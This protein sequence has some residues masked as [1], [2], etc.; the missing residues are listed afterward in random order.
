MD[1][2]KSLESQRRVMRTPGSVRVYAN[3]KIDIGIWEEDFLFDDRCFT[4]SVTLD[5]F[6]LGKR[7]SRNWEG[8]S[9]GKTGTEQPGLMTLHFTAVP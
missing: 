3:E 2:F 6:N 1:R 9:T 8:G 4:T 7:V 5:R